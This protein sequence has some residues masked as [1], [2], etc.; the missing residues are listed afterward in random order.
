MIET[1]LNHVGGH[2]RGVAG[3]YNRST[4][5]REKRLALDMWGAHIE[6]LVEGPSP[7]W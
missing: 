7:L 2:K 6:A 1:L 5:E 4:Y 3:I